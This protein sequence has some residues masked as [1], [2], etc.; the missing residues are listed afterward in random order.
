VLEVDDLGTRPGLLGRDISEAH[1]YKTCWKARPD[2]NCAF[3]T[4]SGLSPGWVRK[5]CSDTD[6]PEIVDTHC[7]RSPSSQRGSG[8]QSRE[9]HGQVK[10][11][12]VEQNYLEV[13][14]E[15]CPGGVVRRPLGY[16]DS[17][18][19]RVAEAPEAVTVAQ[20]LSSWTP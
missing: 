16:Q 6:L 9:P 4:D 8:S 3:T 5:S 2:V 13:V 19:F 17:D 12:A 10:I 7:K 18:D 1:R 11:V 14:T 20:H 15:V